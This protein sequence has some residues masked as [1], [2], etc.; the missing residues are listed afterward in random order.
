MLLS[1]SSNQGDDSKDSED[2]YIHQMIMVKL[3]IYYQTIE[4]VMRMTMEMKK[5]LKL[6]LH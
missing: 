1:R 4:L 5:W 2:D 3:T 6:I